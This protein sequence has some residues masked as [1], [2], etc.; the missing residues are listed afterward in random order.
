M[1]EF[2]MPAEKGLGADEQGGP[3]WPWEDSAQGGEEEPVARL[4]ARAAD[5]ALENGELVTESEDL[6]TEPEL[7]LATNQ[8]EVEQEA[9]Q[10]VE[11]GE[12]HDGGAWH[13]QG[14]PL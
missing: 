7:G 14:S 5:L 9:D 8:Q 12:G 1:E 6:S 4:P 10:G 13:R 2:A 3:G 11:E